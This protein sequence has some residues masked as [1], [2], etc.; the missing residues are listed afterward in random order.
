M[1]V[2]QCPHCRRKAVRDSTGV[3][4]PHAQGCTYFI[5]NRVVSLADKSCSK[6][7][8]DKK[9][10][11]HSWGKIKAGGKGWFFQK[12]GTAYCPEHVPDWVE[13]WR[14]RNGSQK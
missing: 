2:D 11:D 10:K 12:D 7:G 13:E 1:E 4:I 9:Y 5:T 3:T 8:C 6:E 14:G